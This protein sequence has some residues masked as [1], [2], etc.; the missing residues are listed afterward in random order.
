[1]QRPKLELANTPAIGEGIPAITTTH[2]RE[3]GAPLFTAS[4][5]KTLSGDR[6]ARQRHTATPFTPNI[7]RLADGRASVFARRA[8][9]FLWGHMNNYL[10]AGLEQLVHAKVQS[11]RFKFSDEAIT[12]AAR[13]CSLPRPF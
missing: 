7:E 10:S 5:H 8:S 9:I 2:Q 11:N 12:A 4:P 6:R 1:M 13:L 3:I